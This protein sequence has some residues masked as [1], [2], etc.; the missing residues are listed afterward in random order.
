MIKYYKEICLK[1]GLDTEI[2]DENSLKKLENLVRDRNIISHG[3]KNGIVIEKIDEVEEYI[4]TIRILMDNFILSI[5][6]FIENE[7]YLK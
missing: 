3:E 2:F 6:D 4:S 5:Y 7:G 1:I